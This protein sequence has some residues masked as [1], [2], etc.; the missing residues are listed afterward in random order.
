MKVYDCEKQ[1]YI[2]NMNQK[3]V[4]DKIHDICRQYKP[5]YQWYENYCLLIR[6]GKTNNDGTKGLIY[7]NYSSLPHNIRSDFWN[8]C[9]DN[10]LCI[11]YGRCSAWN[12]SSFDDEP[13][14]YHPTLSFRVPYSNLI[15]Q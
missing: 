15:P 12:V 10:D 6:F 2:L 3:L 14:W 7:T 8:L 5:R 1:K 9:Q 13:H 4:L 11:T